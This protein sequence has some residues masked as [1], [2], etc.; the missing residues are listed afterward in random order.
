M[1]ISKKL[2]LYQ[3]YSFITLLV[4]FYVG[5][6]T[7]VH[8][9][10]IIILGILIARIGSEAGFHRLFSHN[11]YKVSPIKETILLLWGTCMGIGSSIGWANTHRLHHKYSDTEYDPHIPMLTTALTGLKSGSLSHSKIVTR[12]LM[13]KP[14]HAFTHKHYF[15]ILS[16]YVSI[17]TSV[18]IMFKTFDIVLLGF[19]IPNLVLHFL[20]ELNLDHF[21]GYTNFKTDD[22]SKNS[23]LIRF[24]LLG[25]GLHNNH[26][27]DPT[28]ANLNFRN[29]W[30]EFDLDYF[31]IKLLFENK[32]HV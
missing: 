14:L 9:F 24:S 23:N 31:F 10:I 28:A 22:N 17:L 16:V 18:S 3:I 12:D 5:S 8:A 19:A 32:K 7:Y 30:W 6:P 13:R 11:S 15:V 25:A 29:Q 2:R 26:H 1:T 27:Y 21:A 4:W 20:Y